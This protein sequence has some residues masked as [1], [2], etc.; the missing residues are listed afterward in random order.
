MAKFPSRDVGGLI[1][2]GRRLLSELLV[3]LAH[4]IESLRDS[5]MEVKNELTRADVGSGPGSPVTD[6]SFGGS[7]LLSWAG[8]LTDGTQVVI[9]SSVDYRYRMLVLTGRMVYH[10]NGSY[11]PG[12]VRSEQIRWEA[13]EQN[14]QVATSRFRADMY[15]GKGMTVSGSPPSLTTVYTPGTTYFCHVQWEDLDAV[16]FDTGTYPPEFPTE[17]PPNYPMVYFWVDETT[18]ALMGMRDRDSV[19]VPVNQSPP[20]D[21]DVVML[22]RV[23]PQLY[24]PVP[25]P[26]GGY[27]GYGGY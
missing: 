22:V 18:G 24:S 7:L 16:Y 27:G 13:E 25:P 11:L 26:P 14:S 5:S 20:Y 1:S 21:V 3:G 19:F 23:M 4:T 10:G 15:S 17:D 8:T 9:D 6:E 2:E 12:Q